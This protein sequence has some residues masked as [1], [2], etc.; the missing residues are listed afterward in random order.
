MTV[1]ARC[2]IALPLTI[3]VACTSAESRQ[4]AMDS[5]AAVAGLSR[6][7]T[8]DLTADLSHLSDKER[9]M[10]PL[11]IDAAKE[12]DAIYWQQAYGNK[13]SL[14]AS[15]PDGPVRRFAEINYGPW[16][17]LAKNAPIV[18]GVGPAPP[19]A[20]FYPADMTQDEFDSVAASRGGA[21]LKSPYS[22]VRR[23]PSR[24]LEALSYASAFQTPLGIAAAKLREA[25]ALAEDP[26]LKTY[27]ESR[28]DALVTNRFQASDMAWMDMK[29]NRIDIVI[30][31]IETY[32]DALYGLKAAN[33]AF[34]LI[35]DPE[36]SKRLAKYVG[37][38]PQ[39]Q[40]GLPVPDEY[41]QEHPSA[42]SDLNAYDV[43]YYAGE[44]NKVPKTIAINLPNDET[45]Q[46]QK[47][48]RRLQLKN[49][50]HAKFD[51]IML[52]IAAELIAD[53]QRKHVTFD[54]FF[55]NTMF[56]EVAHGLGIK[57]TLNGKGTVRAA[58]M[59]Q[60]ASIEEGKADILGLHMV[61]ALHDSGELKDV[62]LMDHYVTFLAG[63]IRSVRF[64]AGDAHGTANMA[65]FNFFEAQGAFTRDAA[66]GTYA[67]NFEKMKT[68]MNALSEKLLRFEGDGDFDGAKRFTAQSGTIPASLQADLA[69]LRTKNIPVDIVFR[70]G[71]DVM[72]K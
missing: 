71:M 40:R 64:G 4:R 70:Q 60:Y 9:Q 21:V 23:G 44:A 26:G 7:V 24:R 52:P 56:H 48:T 54:A 33:E 46:L 68:A 5:A 58:L 22:M 8:V 37:M 30:G 6:Y 72:G 38:L 3:L 2:A 28:A 14:L 55:G 36:W 51:K 1:I 12:M 27:L 62:D 17:R 63:I 35:K 69:R 67:V 47:G 29:N 10:L 34:V 57:N 25:A 32:E 66:K 43:V 59:A 45:V 50:M 16:D 15:L 61:T 53:D 65:C 11:L 20:N 18:A 49:A 31:P 19:G 39:L 13:D 42:N 41:K